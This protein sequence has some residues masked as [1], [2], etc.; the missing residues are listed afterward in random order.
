MKGERRREKMLK[1]LLANLRAGEKVVLSYFPNQY[2]DNMQDEVLAFEGGQWRLSYINCHSSQMLGLG[3]CQCH[4]HAPYGE[5]VISR[6]EALRLLEDYVKENKRD[7][8]ARKAE[9]AWLEQ[10]IRE[11]AAIA[12][13]N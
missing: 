11:T 6:K 9:I 10:A 3:T 8:R 13:M 5:A 2:G 12:I 1:N 7:E 4:S